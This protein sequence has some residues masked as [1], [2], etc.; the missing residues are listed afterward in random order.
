[1][2]AANRLP[3]R[4]LATLSH[5]MQADLASPRRCWHNTRMGSFRDWSAFYDSEAWDQL[6]RYTLRRYGRRCM[7]CGA[8]DTELHVDH[9]WP[10][11]RYPQRSLDA[12]NLQVLCRACNYQKGG[13]IL[14]YRNG[15][16]RLI[17]R[18]PSDAPIF[19]TIVAVLALAYLLASFVL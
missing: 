6:R 19:M 5:P 17:R 18:A 15:D 12:E 8:T 1:M 2:T 16:A 3:A 14:D 7:C 4:H 10:M 13:R 11:S 9:I